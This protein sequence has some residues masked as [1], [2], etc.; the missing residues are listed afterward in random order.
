MDRLGVIELR[1]WDVA[2]TRVKSEGL[3][4]GKTSLLCSKPERWMEP[5]V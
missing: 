2:D 3:R 5:D 4:A 1:C